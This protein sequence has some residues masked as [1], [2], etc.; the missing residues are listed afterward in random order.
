MKKKLK[1]LLS[2][3][4]II[5][6]LLTGCSK[7]NKLIAPSNLRLE[8]T[9]LIWNKVEE[10]VK[11]RLD[12]VKEGVS[13]K[14]VVKENQV[15]LNELDLEEGTYNIKVQAIAS[16]E[17]ND[18]DYSKESIQYIQRDLDKVFEFM[19]ENLEDSRYIKWMGRST[20]SK[21]KGLK[22]LYHTASGFEV[23]FKG[24]RVTTR[25]F[26]TSYDNPTHN[27]FVSIVVDDD[28]DNQRRIEITKEYTDL[29]LI[30]GLSDNQIHKVALYKSTESQDGIIGIEKINTTGEFIA[31]MDVKSHKIEFIGDSGSCGFGN[32]NKPSEQRTSEGSDGMKAFAALT[33]IALDADFQI[34]AASGWGIKASIY[35]TPNTVNVFDAYKNYDFSGSGAAIKYDYSSFIPDLV[36]INL[37][38]ND[39]SYIYAAVTDPTEYEKR[40]NDYKE[41]YIA[42]VNFIHELYPNAHIL[43]LH[44]LMNEGKVIADATN[45]LYNLLKPQIENLS[46]IQIN[47]DGQGASNHP[48]AKSHQAI[49]D[50]LVQ[51]IKTTLGW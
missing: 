33:G 50:Q 7:E 42:M 49:A 34:F 26:A 30:D 21:L 16:N 10:A 17:K 4:L 12:L 44:G 25:I 9:I 20:Y 51:H 29:V 28:F 22:M 23:K 45:E 47:G 37:G 31:D 27:P 1:F 46:T 19:G 38:T 18:S 8:E 40:L 6:I 48:S 2:C 36:V 43:M 24:E 13:M 41:Q 5:V 11:Y 32:L 3:L 15:D 39:Y 14:R 35:T